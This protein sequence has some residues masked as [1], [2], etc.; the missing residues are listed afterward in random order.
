[1]KDEKVSFKEFMKTV[2]FKDNYRATLRQMVKSFYP[3]QKLRISIGNSLCASF[4]AKI[5][6]EPGQKI[7]SA[8]DPWGKQILKEYLNEYKLLSEAIAGNIREL[9]K[10]LDKRKGIIGSK[11]EYAMVDSFFTFKDQEDYIKKQLKDYLGNFAIWNDFLLHVPGVGPLMGS[12]IISEFDIYKARYV[13]S[14]WAYAGFGVMADGKGQSKRREHLTEKEYIDRDGSPKTKMGINFNP[15]LKTKLAG[16]LGPSFLKVHAVKIKKDGIGYKYGALYYN[17]KN[18]ITQKRNVTL[19]GKNEEQIKEIMK[20]NLDARIN[21]ASIRYIVKIF[22][23]DL[24]P[25]WKAVEGLPAVAPYAERKLGM[26]ISHHTTS[27]KRGDPLSDES[28]RPSL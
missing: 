6:V 3:I 27:Q 21:N 18:R 2:K 17:Y 28:P 1:M 24:Y 12:V 20:E 14:L 4:Y 15:F 8:K 5:G 9:N 22:L 16:V 23:Q 25:V 13:S 19:F 10:V 11:V 7:K 26:N